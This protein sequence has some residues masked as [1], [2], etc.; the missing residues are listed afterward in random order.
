MDKFAY[1]LKLGEKAVIFRSAD[2]SSVV[3]KPA[4]KSED[5]TAEDGASAARAAQAWCDCGWPYTVLLPRG[6]KNGMNFR[7][8][9]MCSDGDKLTLPDHPESCTSLSYCGLENKDYPDR[10]A[11]GYPFDRRFDRSITET[12]QKYDNWAWRTIEICCQNI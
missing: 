10:M 1:K 5:L 8:L 9:V 12:V 4:L 3:R 11:M 2:R 7:L 6:T